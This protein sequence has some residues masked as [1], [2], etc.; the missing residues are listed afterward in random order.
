MAALLATGGAYALASIRWCRVPEPKAPALQVV[1]AA[2]DPLKVGAG[3]VALD[4]PLP[5]VV[6]G[7]GPPRSVANRVNHPL[8]ARALVF[9]SGPVTLGVVALDTLLVPADLARDVRAA[10]G[11]TDTWVVATHTH[12]SFGG[13]DE[14]W[15]AQLAATGRPNASARAALV[16]GAVEALRRARADLRPAAV[17]AG[18]LPRAEVSTPRSGAASDERLLR[19]AFEGSAGTVGELLVASAH[20]TLVP[21]RTESLDPDW[22]GDAAAGREAAGTQVTLV[23][24]AAGGN[25]RAALRDGESA[26]AYAE[27]VAGQAAGAPVLALPGEGLAVARVQVTLPRVDSSRLVPGF[28]RNPGDNFLCLDADQTAEVAVARVGG[29]TL[30]AVPAEVTL[31]SALQLEP[32]AGADRVLSLAGGYL[33]YVEPA[34]TVGQRGG[35]SRRQYY[36]PELLDVLVQGATAAA[37]AL[38]LAA[39]PTGP[40]APSPAPAPPAPVAQ[41]PTPATDAG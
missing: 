12:S 17:A 27:R 16:Q 3:K 6:A 8:H 9:E 26:Q 1:A 29:A 15:T 35:E 20:P 11:L 18:V 33:G 2:R 14:R 37:Q 28:G 31:D 23:L 4:P 7:Y 24:Q 39:G 25:A 5:S 38:A 40:G 21:R 30:L 41:P 34:A 36:A 13:H 22:P 32:A 10:A 19:L